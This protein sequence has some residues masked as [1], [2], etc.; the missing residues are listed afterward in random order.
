[1]PYDVYANKYFKDK[2]YN[3]KRDYYRWDYDTQLTYY[4]YLIKLFESNNKIFVYMYR[5]DKVLPTKKGP[6]VI[7]NTLKNII[8]YFR[9]IGFKVETYD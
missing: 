5:A 7:I 2:Q 4:N 1:M 3:S 9:I 6:K 8:A